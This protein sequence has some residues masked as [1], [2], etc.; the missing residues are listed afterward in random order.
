MSRIAIVGGGVAGLSAAA[1][2]SQDGH[3]VQLFEAEAQLG[4][5]AS[6]R[7][8]AMFEENYG[9]DVVRAL[10]RGTGPA[11]SKMGVLSPRGILMVACASDAEAFQ[12]DLAAMGMTEVTLEEARA[13]I[14]IL[15]DDVAFAAVHEG[16]ADVDTHG[17]LQH[18]A[19]QAR[20]HGARIHTGA[21]V[22]AVRP[23]RSLMVDGGEVMADIV[24]NAA[25][26]WADD[27]AELAG[28]ARIGLTPYRR[29][30]A[31]LPAPGGYDVRSWPMLYGA[32]ERW[33]AKP[34]AGG[35]IVS[36]AEEDPIAP[37]DAW[38]DDMVLAEGMARYDAHV[39]EPVTRV[40]TSWAGLRTFAPDRALV[41][42]EDAH[43]PGF[44]WLAGQ[45]GYGFQTCV[46]AAAH[47]SALIAGRG[48]DLAPD[49]AKALSPERFAG[50]HT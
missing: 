28:V 36:P 50:G 29:S 1:A 41:I 12:A 16:A 39:T 34:D 49:V 11:L 44:F 46:A 27:V 40:E 42:G 8:A 18:F 3:D 24:V 14:P 7:S 30:M 15:S 17:V 47:L 19:K 21:K 5:H 6:G 26:A 43:A 32:G 45:G 20:H 38:A 13:R 4:Y 37:M 2:L 9:N 23:G 22:T 10:N 33:Y 31:R 25:G 48:S 35:W